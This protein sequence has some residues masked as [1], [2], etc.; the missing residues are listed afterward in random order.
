[1]K[2]QLQHTDSRSA[3][4]AGV[5]STDHGEILTPIFMPV[6]TVGSVKGI[7]HRDLKKVGAQ[8]I[9]GN[10][11]HLYLR[12]GTDILEKAGGLH[13]F[14]SWDRP[15][16]TDSGGF[17]VFSL[18]EC[19]KLTEEGCRF[20]SH[21]DG[22][23]HMFTPENVIDIQRSIGAD[24]MMAFDECPPGDAEYGYAKQS[25]ERTSRW[26][27]RCFNTEESLGDYVHKQQT[28]N[29]DGEFVD[30]EDEGSAD[31]DTEEFYG[32]DSDNE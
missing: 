8:I 7:F 32:E 30:V 22:S 2:F 25:W 9:L 28:V 14:C 4:R 20:H 24:I 6:G 23:L 1:M 31:D 5:I 13:R 21:I 19:R 3:A 16:L 17:Q 26:L 27:E 12:P 15:I 18:A 11:Y 10:T 29:S